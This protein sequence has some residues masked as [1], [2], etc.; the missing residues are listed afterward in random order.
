MDED[1]DAQFAREVHH[2]VDEVVVRRI[3]VEERVQLHS[4]KAL[5]R[6]STADFVE[7][8]GVRRRDPRDRDDEVRRGAV[9]GED[10]VVVVAVRAREECLFDVELGHLLAEAREI[11]VEPRPGAEV[12]DVGVGIDDFHGE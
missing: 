7:R 11:E 1:R 12:A 8:A 6:H 4:A 9:G 5:P 2:R 3:G 10:G